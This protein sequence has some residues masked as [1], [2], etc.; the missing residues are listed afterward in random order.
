MYRISRMQGVVTGAERLADGVTFDKSH[1]LWAEL[2]AWNA[3]QPIPLDLSDK[4]PE[5]PAPRDPDAEDFTPEERKR[6]RA[7]LK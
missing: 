5:P 2:A 3:K 6:L 7:L 1:P 4:E